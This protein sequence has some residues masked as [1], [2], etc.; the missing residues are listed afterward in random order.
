LVFDRLRQAGLTLNPA[1]CKFGQPSVKLLGHI[2]DKEGIQNDP[3]KVRAINGLPPPKDVH[4]VRSFLGMTGYY[5]DS[6]QDYAKIAEPLTRLIRVKEKFLWGPEQDV[7]F[8]T[9]KTMLMSGEVMA[10]PDASRP[11]KL[12]TDA[13]DYAIGGILVQEDPIT[14]REK[15]ICYVSHQ[16]GGSKLNWSTIEKEGYAVVYSMG[17]I[18][19]FSLTINL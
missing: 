12:Y 11:Y 14:G 2:I 19:R 6:I 15:V 8:N 17:L 16:L 10:Y 9:L 5:H 1:K 4:G 3:A 18:L 13:C 7:A